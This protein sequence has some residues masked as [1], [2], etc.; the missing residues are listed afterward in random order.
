MFREP[1]FEVLR[2]ED[3]YHDWL[4]GITSSVNVVSFQQP[5]WLIFFR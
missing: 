2:L 4:N 3:F 5:Q 1:W